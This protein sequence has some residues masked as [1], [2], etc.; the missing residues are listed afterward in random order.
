MDCRRALGWL[1]RLSF[2]KVIRHTVAWYLDNGAW[3]ENIA[4]GD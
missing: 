3:S 2:D 1:P 4:S